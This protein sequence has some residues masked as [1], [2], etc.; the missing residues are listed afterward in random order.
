MG[1]WRW[2]CGARD[3]CAHWQPSAQRAVLKCCLENPQARVRGWPGLTGMHNIYTAAWQATSPDRTRMIHVPVCYDAHF[4]C[5]RGGLWH[6]GE[7]W[8][9]VSSVCTPLPPTSNT[10][11]KCPPCLCAGLGR[12]GSRHPG[13][14]PAHR[15][16]ARH[17]CAPGGGPHP[18][19]PA[20]SSPLQPARCW[21][22]L[23]GGQ[24]REGHCPGCTS[25]GPVG[26]VAA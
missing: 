2:E 14:G 9:A 18:R 7:L 3:R 20:L 16:P 17:A 8:P 12:A 22:P 4:P 19:L 21:R 6:A 15:R 24:E 26:A 10:P 1:S 13:V 5:P 25:A 11:L 23:L